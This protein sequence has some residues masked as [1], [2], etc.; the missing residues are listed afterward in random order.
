M[1]TLFKYYHHAS[2]TW[3][4]ETFDE[5]DTPLLSFITDAVS[6]EAICK[7]IKLLHPHVVRIITH[8]E[9][10]PFNDSWVPTNHKFHGIEIW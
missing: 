9:Q 6:A 3:Y 4:T 5:S 1:V 2:P 8:G 10:W 7:Q